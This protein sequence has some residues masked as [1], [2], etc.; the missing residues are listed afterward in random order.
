MKKTE[1]DT[2]KTTINTRKLP[3]RRRY[4]NKMIL[5]F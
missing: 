4:V 3:A 1:F 2:L 5:W